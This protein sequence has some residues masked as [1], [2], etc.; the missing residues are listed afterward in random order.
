MHKFLN[1]IHFFQAIIC[2]FSRFLYLYECL[3]YAVCSVVVRLDI[4]FFSSL[5]FMNDLPQPKRHQNLVL[6]SPSS[7]T[8]II[9]QENYCT[10]FFYREKR[11]NSCTFIKELDNEKHEEHNSMSIKKT[12]YI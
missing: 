7:S 5:G 8:T 4:L 12:G 3:A 1:L 9:I 2:S 11:Q 6:T 10:L